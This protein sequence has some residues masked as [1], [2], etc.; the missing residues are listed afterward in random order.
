MG[1]LAT[2][3]GEGKK[4]RNS[5]LKFFLFIYFI[6]Q[7]ICKKLQAAIDKI[8]E[9]RYDAEAKVQKADKD[10]SNTSRMLVLPPG[11]RK[12]PCYAIL[13]ASAS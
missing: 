4:I 6:L 1:E 3:L 11:G 7:E 9:A 10:V 2:K 5:S 8:D 13:M 12:R